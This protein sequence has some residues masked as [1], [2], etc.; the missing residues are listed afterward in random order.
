MTDSKFNS[1]LKSNE[2]H[3]E[4]LKDFTS[5]IELFALYN[6]GE[7]EINSLTLNILFLSGG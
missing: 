4:N 1:L 2:V 5:L 6:F 7:C 3:E